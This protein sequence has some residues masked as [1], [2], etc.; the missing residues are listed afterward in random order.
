MESPTNKSSPF[1]VDRLMAS[2]DAAAREKGFADHDA[3]HA[4]QL[5]IEAARVESDRLRDLAQ[6]RE[7]ASRILVG[8]FPDSVAEEI[9][10]GKPPSSPTKAWGAVQAWLASPKP[11]LVLAG[12][13]GGG[14]TVAA[15]RAMAES[16]CRSQFIR[17]VQVGAHY[18]R[19]SSDRES[20]VQPLDVAV[21]FMVVDDLG[22]E[23]MDDR[24]TELA[25]DEI[26]D[27]RQSMSRRTI[28]TTN[29][30]ADELRSRYSERVRSRWA[31]SALVKRVD[32]SDRRRAK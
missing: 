11:M 2:L 3:W 21:G 22:M 4:R 12:A 28:F 31:Q 25:L 7:W 19:W 20:G 1:D 17:A 32:E 18:E 24:R 30:T 5:E 15:I 13:T 27:A 9:R 29:L 26:V 10:A 23:S 16:G 8:R 14:K 6:H